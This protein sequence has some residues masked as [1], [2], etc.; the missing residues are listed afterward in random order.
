[1]LHGVHLAAHGEAATVADTVDVAHALGRTTAVGKDEVGDPTVAVG[2][3]GAPLVHLHGPQARTAVHD[4]VAASLVVDEP[5]DNPVADVGVEEEAF[6]L[7]EGGVEVDGYLVDIGTLAHV[8]QSLLQT[9]IVLVVQHH[10]DAHG[11]RGPPLRLPPLAVSADVLVEA[12]ERALSANAIVPLPHSVHRHPHL[13]GMGPLEGQLGI[14]GDGDAPESYLVGQVDDVVDAIG[15]ARL[16]FVLPE[17]EFAAF[18]IDEARALAVAVFQF[19]TNLGKGLDAWCGDGIDRAVA[20]A[21]I[22]AVEDEDD[23]L[24]GGATAHEG[25]QLPPGKVGELANTAEHQARK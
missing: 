19:L 1:M 16:R 2:A 24:Q 14:G 6:G 8:L 15:A 17:V 9:G 3:A 5:V 4:G 13:V 12:F 25:S 7:A 20:A 18:E 10:V 21:Q 22:A 23:G 11:G